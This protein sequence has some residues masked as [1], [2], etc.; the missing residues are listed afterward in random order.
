MDRTIKLW[1]VDE[2]AYIETLFGHQ[3][4][5]TAI[6]TLQRERCVTSGARDR[7]VRMWKIL[8]ESQL[9]YRAGSGNNTGEEVEGSFKKDTKKA[10]PYGGSLDAVALID[11]DHFVSGSDSG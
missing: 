6:D 10:R 4:N 9:V 1:N 2:L 3:D 8:E 7:T 5:I 11:E